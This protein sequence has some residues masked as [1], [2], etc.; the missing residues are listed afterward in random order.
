VNLCVFEILWQVI[1]ECYQATKAL[2]RTKLFCESLCL[3]DFSIKVAGYDDFEKCYAGRVEK[4]KEGFSDPFMG[5]VIAWQ[6]RVY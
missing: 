5:R 2:N 6:F 3:R 4:G 1:K